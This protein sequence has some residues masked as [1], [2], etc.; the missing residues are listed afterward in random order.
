[1][2]LICILIAISSFAVIIAQTPNRV[3]VDDSTVDVTDDTAIK[4][5]G[6]DG[7]LLFLANL[8]TNSNYTLQILASRQYA[9]NRESSV[10][11]PYLFGYKLRVTTDQILL[12]DIQT[13]PETPSIFYNIVLKYDSDGTIHYLYRN[14]D[15]TTKNVQRL[16]EI[17]KENTPCTADELKIIQEV[18]FQLSVSYSVPIQKIKGYLQFEDLRQQDKTFIS[19]QY[20]SDNHHIEVQIDNEDFMSWKI[21][22]TDTLTQLQYVSEI[23]FIQWARTGSR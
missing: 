18:V 23:E 7:Q 5:R 22:E 1:M 8:V 14:N 2:F 9:D 15:N 17:I 20:T 12:F 13:P 16:A 11:K 4:D 19:E 10:I 6:V 3:Q 21:Q